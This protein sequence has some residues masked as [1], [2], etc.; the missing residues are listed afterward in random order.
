[1]TSAHVARIMCPECSQ[2]VPVEVTFVDGEA[3][4]V[5]VLEEHPHRPVAPQALLDQFCTELAEE[6]AADPVD[7]WEELGDRPENHQYIDG[8]GRRR[9][10]D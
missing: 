4:A 8:E 2:P 9:W 3:V 1:M 6:A 7:A 5:E 10:I